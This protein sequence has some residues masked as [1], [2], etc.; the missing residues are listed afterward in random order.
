MTG[1]P[2]SCLSSAVNRA[3]V[4]IPRVAAT[5]PHPNVCVVVSVLGTGFGRDRCI[6]IRG[7]CVVHND[8]EA[9]CG[10]VMPIF[11]Q[12]LEFKNDPER[13]IAG[14]LEVKGSVCLEVRP[15]RLSTSDYNDIMI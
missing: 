4:D 12:K 3:P 11:V 13:S 15:E 9:V 2:A 1:F 7:K 6:S 14:L 8:K 10:E 5:R